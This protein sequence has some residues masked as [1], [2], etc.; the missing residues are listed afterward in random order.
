MY[1]ADNHE[2][3]SAGCCGAEQV[4]GCCG[5]EQ[6]PVTSLRNKHIHKLTCV[7]ADMRAC[8]NITCVLKLV[9]LHSTDPQLR[10]VG[11]TPALLTSHQKMLC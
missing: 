8:P 1:M 4:P 3:F 9:C 10:H 11:G 7:H 6:V 5:A 2:L